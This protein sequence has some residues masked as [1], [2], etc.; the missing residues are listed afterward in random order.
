MRPI[1]S[2]ENNSVFYV[3]EIMAYI[4]VAAADFLVKASKESN[5]KHAAGSRSARAKAP[6][7]F[8]Q[9]SA[10]W[11]RGARIVAISAVS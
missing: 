10:A 4:N 3:A 9:L 8:L 5:N 6:L 2:H 11:R 1:I 7:I